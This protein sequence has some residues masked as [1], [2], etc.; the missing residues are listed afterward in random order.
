VFEHVRTSCSNISRPNRL[1]IV[2]EHLTLEPFQLWYFTDGSLPERVSIRAVPPYLQGHPSFP[3]KLFGPLIR[4]L[5]EHLFELQMKVCYCSVQYNVFSLVRWWFEHA[6]MIGQFDTDC[7]ND[8]HPLTA[9]KGRKDMWDVRGNRNGSVAARTDLRNSLHSSI[10]RTLLLS[11]PEIPNLSNEESIQK[12]EESLIS[13]LIWSMSYCQW[14]QT[15][16]IRSQIG[17][18]VIWPGYQPCV[19][20]SEGRSGDSEFG[21]VYLNFWDKLK[22]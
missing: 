3:G 10:W 14:A 8:S 2:F 11:L 4:C 15:D 6:H 17:L 22:A 12:S 1:N 19:C 21:S 20:S 16:R 18:R 13:R 9:R 5:F 7:S